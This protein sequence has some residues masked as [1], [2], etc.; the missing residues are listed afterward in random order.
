MVHSKSYT[1]TTAQGMHLWGFY[2]PHFY[3]NNF[4]LGYCAEKSVNEVYLI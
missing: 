2:P 4:L 3:M 1:H